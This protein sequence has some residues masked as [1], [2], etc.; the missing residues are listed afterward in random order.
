[1]LFFLSAH[2]LESTFIGLEIV[3]EHRNY[4]ASIGPLM[5]LAYLIVHGS[6]LPRVGLAAMTLGALLLLTHAVATWVR[7]DN[8]SSYEKFVL[9]A[10]D[11]HPDSPRSNFMAAQL[12]I[13]MIANTKGDTS[14]LEATAETFLDQGLRADP[15]CINCLFG[16]VVLAIHVDRVPDPGLLDQL[17]SALRTGFV[18]ATKV[19][20]SQFSYL[21]KWQQ[22]DGVKIPSAALEKLFDDALQNPR[23]LPTGRAGIEA[24]YREYHEFVTGDLERAL[25]H[26]DRAIDAWPDQWSYHMHKVRVL[27]KLSSVEAALTALDVAERLAGNDDQLSRVEKRR[28]QI[29]NGNGN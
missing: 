22:S 14:E 15:N 5:L 25:V 26:A 12:V 17:S 16:K 27:H 3:F 11:N 7:V 2:A 18:G 21:V 19:S 20:V 13:S 28:Q 10:A 9:N 24:A 1:M 8:W 29:M 4:L 6:R 23:W